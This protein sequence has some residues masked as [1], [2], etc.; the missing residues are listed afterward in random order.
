MISIKSIIFSILFVT[1]AIA[2]SSA[3]KLISSETELRIDNKGNVEIV[4]NKTQKILVNSSICNMFCLE[5]FNKL[6]GEKYSLRLNSEFQMYQKEDEIIVEAN[7]YNPEKINLPITTKLIISKKEEAFCFSGHVVC[8]S[9]WVIKDLDYP[10]FTIKN[11]QYSLYWPKGLGEYYAEAR[12][13]DSEASGYPQ[14]AGASMPW[15]SFNSNNSGIYIAC[16]DST[17]SSKTFNLVYQKDKNNFIACFNKQLYKSEYLIPEYILKKYSGSWHQA[18]NYYRSWWN[19]H[20][21]VASYPAWVIDDSGWLLAILKQQNGEIMWPYNEIDKLSDIAKKHNLRTIGLFGWAQGG[22]DH[23]YPNYIPD[24][25][26]GGSKELSSAIERAHQHGMKIILYAN[27][28]IMDTSTDFYLYNG[29]EIIYQDRSGNPDIQFYR[30]YDNI[31][32]VIFAQACTGSPLWRKIMFDLA[33]QAR[34]LGADGIL[35]DQVGA[36]G[37]SACFSKYHDHAPGE[38]DSE[39]RVKMVSEIRQKMKRIDPDFIVMTEGTND[40]ILKEIDY[41]HGWG[42]GTSISKNAFPGL[43]RYTFPEVVITQR[44]AKPVLTKE[45]VNFALIYGLK[46]EL[47]CRYSADKEYLLHGM[48]PTKE[49]YLHVNDVP[50]V[51]KLARTS[52]EEARNYL[53]QIIQFE[54]EHAIFL[55]YGKYIDDKGICIEGKD[56]LAKGYLNKDKIGIVV[57]NQ[58]ITEP[59]EFSITVPGFHL[60]KISEPGNADLKGNEP[61]EANS[62]RFVVFKANK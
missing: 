40:V 46:H 47:E 60:E 27:G 29:I 5:V 35:Y 62:I 30:K 41:T 42:K 54:E 61:I 15:Y 3:F 7:Q 13:F 37:A 56:I 28:K 19:N 18:S 12:N 50:D 45:D 2:G 43:Y 8:D 48:I 1:S 57:W 51:S 20:F 25:L 34:S 14:S 10:I 16:H 21:K 17:Q 11:F 55:R 33:L 39:Y 23:L 53:H 31:T 32:P 36:V 4:E 38:S 59:R 22:H 58:N 9:N 44:N 52:V 24:P 6:S 26:M 49:N